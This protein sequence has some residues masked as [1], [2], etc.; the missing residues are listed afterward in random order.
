MTTAIERRKR[1]ATLSYKL[2]PVTSKRTRYRQRHL[3]VDGRQSFSVGHERKDEWEDT[4]RA[5]S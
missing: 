3:M 5:R 4:H 1:S 2:S